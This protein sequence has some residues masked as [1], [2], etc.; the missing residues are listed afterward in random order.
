MKEQNEQ[1]AEVIYEQVK[2]Q[3]QSQNDKFDEK[4]WEKE[5]DI[6]INLTSLETELQKKDVLFLK[7]QYENLKTLKSIEQLLRGKF[8]FSD[9]ILYNLKFEL[10]LWFGFLIIDFIFVT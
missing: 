4:A 3:I 8:N 5:L 7:V 6:D 10:I 1:Q 9:N 2:R